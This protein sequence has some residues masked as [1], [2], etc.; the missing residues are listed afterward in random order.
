MLVVGRKEAEAGSVAV[1]RHG[2]GDQ[3]VKS[4][5]EFIEDAMAEVAA[6]R[7]GAVREPVSEA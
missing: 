6:G 2:E 1:R 5:D 3:G 4:L 7:S